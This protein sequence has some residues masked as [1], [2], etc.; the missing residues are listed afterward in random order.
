MTADLFNGMDQPF[1]K[2]LLDKMDNGPE[3]QDALLAM[4][5]Q[6]T[7]PNVFIGGQHLGGNDDCQGAA[8]AGK[9]QEMLKQ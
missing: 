7:V 8:R 6:R 5:G 4:T 1:T 3:V 2:I 9:L